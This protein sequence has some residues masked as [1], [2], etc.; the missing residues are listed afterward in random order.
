MQGSH[1]KKQNYATELSSLPYNKKDIMSKVM[2]KMLYFIDTGKVP[3]IKDQMMNGIQM[4]A[5]I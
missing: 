1:A 2:N 3:I 4:F 5:P